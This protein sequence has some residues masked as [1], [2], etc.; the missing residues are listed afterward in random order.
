MKVLKIFPLASIL[1]FL[2]FCRTPLPTPAPTN[3]DLLKQLKRFKSQDSVFLE[4][5]K[6]AVT[7]NY[8]L[9]PAI[10]LQQAPFLL[11]YV[12]EVTGDSL[13]PKIAFK[14]DWNFLKSTDAVS[15]D[16]FEKAPF[17]DVYINRSV[18]TNI[19]ALDQVKTSFADSSTYHINYKPIFNASPRNLDFID[20]LKFNK[21]IN[22]YI[23][24]YDSR[25]NLNAIRGSLKMIRSV[26]VNRLA[27]QEFNKLQGSVTGAVSVVNID[28]KMFY[29]GGKEMNQYEVIISTADILWSVTPDLVKTGGSSNSLIQDWH[30]QVDKKAFDKK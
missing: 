29:S 10:F 1:L 7:E 16:L 4:N 9:D 25:G 14:N 3:Q 26:T 23:S 8:Y 22:R 30:P 13:N 21:I 5:R 2:S 27:Y 19:D 24:S 17:L 12:I 15:T 11:G 20:T 6:L 28:G 18:S